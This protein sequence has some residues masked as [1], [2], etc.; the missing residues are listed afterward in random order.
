MY[1][2]TVNA[3]IRGHSSAEVF[4]ALSGFERYPEY[5]SS[6]RSVKMEKLDERR[7]RVEWEVNFRDGIL[8]WTE[9]NT[10]DPLNRSISFKQIAGDIDL[11]TGEWRTQEGEN[12]CNA[13]FSATFD[14]GV[15]S[16]NHILEPIAEQALHENIVMI[17]KGMFG[18]AV[19]LMPEEDISEAI[20]TPED[21]A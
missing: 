18:S 6:V 16:L 14:L 3:R 19:E 15:P 1:R 9:I 20:D 2:M 11:F 21:G 13:R 10:I 5:S 17:F 4:R 8:C 12:Y 7:R